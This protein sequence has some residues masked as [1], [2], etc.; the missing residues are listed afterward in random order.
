MSDP[1]FLTQIKEAK[2]DLHLLSLLMQL[3]PQSEMRVIVAA[4]VRAQEL[5]LLQKETKR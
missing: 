1:D 2:T 5:I 3:F 4:L